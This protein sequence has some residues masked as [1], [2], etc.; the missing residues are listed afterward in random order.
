SRG[1][2]GGGVCSP[3]DRE[4]VGNVSSC[5]R[6]GAGLR[7][8][9]DHEDFYAR[10]MSGDGRRLVY[11]AGGALYLLDPD[12]DEPRRLPVELPSSRTQRNR[13]F[14]SAS[15]YLDTATLSPDGTGLAVTSRRK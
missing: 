4:G 7:R 15:R 13:R 2:L 8:H 14:V 3:S 10:N 5:T 1:W 11:H 6:A 12:E 9:S